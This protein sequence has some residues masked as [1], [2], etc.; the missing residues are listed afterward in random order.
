MNSSKAT[1]KTRVALASIVFLF[2]IQQAT[3]AQEGRIVEITVDSKAI[4]GNMLGDS[5]KR[6]VTVYL[7]PEYDETLDRRFPVVY[8]LHGY[9]GTNKLWTGGG[10]VKGLDISNIADGLIAAGQIK[11]MI[12]VAPDCRNVYGGSWYTN[13][14]VTGNWE[15]FVTQEL[16]QHIDSKYRTIPDRA[17]RGIAGHSMGGHGALKLAMKQPD[18][19][20][21][22]YA[23]SPAWIVFTEAIRGPFAEQLAAA[24]AAKERSDFGKLH[25][26]SRAFIALSAAV[27]PNREHQPFFVELPV[28]A[29]GDRIPHVWKRWLK[30]DPLTMIHTYGRNLLE[31][32]AVAFDCGN[33]EDLLATSQ[34]F[35]KA[36]SDASI[37]HTFEQF[38]GGHINRVASQ[39]RDS[40]LPLFSQTLEFETGATEPEDRAEA[41]ALSVH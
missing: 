31:Y 4:A 14:P 8:L 16:V 23:M 24:V 20:S 22:I 32:N 40:V 39:L 1:R 30:Q 33:E 27:A 28:N 34:V 25:W 38:E 9:L 13:S 36:L 18:L 6:N 17:S 26:R 41:P 29:N 12:L 15:D 7:P 2:A 35:S 19:Y 21:T 3:L 37:D 5:P 10:Y 11:P